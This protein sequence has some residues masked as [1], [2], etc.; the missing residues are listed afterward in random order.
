MNKVDGKVM[1]Q[2]TYPR[3]AFQM[4]RWHV[5]ISDFGEKY[6]LSFLLLSNKLIKYFGRP[7]APSISDEDI[8][9]EIETLMRGK[10]IFSSPV[11]AVKDFHDKLDSEGTCVLLTTSDLQNFSVG[12]QSTGNRKRWNLGKIVM[13][14]T[15]TN[16]TN[17]LGTNCWNPTMYQEI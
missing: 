5:W 4:F 10:G 14:I 2:D 3:A 1:L 9:E 16:Q 12:I 15:I 17:S 13:I 6:V 8:G 11:K 7:G